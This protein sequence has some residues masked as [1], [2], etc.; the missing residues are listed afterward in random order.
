MSVAIFDLKKK[1]IE[2]QTVDSTGMI[3]LDALLIFQH[4][5][6]F[7][8]LFRM[9]IVLLDILVAIDFYVILSP[10][11]FNSSS[12]GN[13]QNFVTCYSPSFFIL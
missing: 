2:S 1:K 11:I 13:C 9:K 5:L 6:L 3:Y 7:S 12:C 8:K 4:R 10:L